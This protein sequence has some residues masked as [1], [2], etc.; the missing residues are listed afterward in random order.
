MF[1]S[2]EEVQAALSMD[3]AHVE[4]ALSQEWHDQEH[5]PG[6][7]CLPLTELMIEWKAFLPEDKLI[8][9]LKDTDPQKRIVTYCG[10]GIAATINATAYLIAGYENV[11][12]YDGSLF[13]WKGE[14]LPV[15]SKG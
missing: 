14:G 10:G 11:A 1:A 4:N 3:S 7:S 6:S 13:E 8:A 12:V 9:R 2:K 15:T 5:I